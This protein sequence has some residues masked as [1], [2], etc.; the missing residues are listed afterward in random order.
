MERAIHRGWWHYVV[1][2]AVTA[3]AAGFRLYF[4]AAL[5]GGSPFI[6]FYP[7][8]VAGALYGGFLAGVLVIGLSIFFASLLWLEPV[9]RSFNIANASDVPGIILFFINGIVISLVCAAVLHTTEKVQERTQRLMDTN[10]RLEEEVEKRSKT[11]QELRSLTMELEARVAE[12]TEELQ[13]KNTELEIALE[14]VVRQNR[15]LDQFAYVVSHDLKAPLRAISNLSQWIKEDLPQE[16]QGEITENLDILQ[17][18]VY[19][20]ENL[21]NGILEYSR[22]GRVEAE[23]SEVNVSQLLQEIVEELS[24]PPGVEIIIAHP[25]PVLYTSKVRLRQ[26]FSNLLDNAI[27]HH[28]SSQGRVS[29]QVEDCGTYCRFSVDDDGPGIAPEFHE[30]IFGIFQTLQPKDKVES[31][32]VGLALV[33]KIV[34]EYGGTIS[35]RSHQGQ[36]A[37][38]RFTWPQ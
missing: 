15:E 38:F 32:G 2:A 11:E 27:K 8:I 20:M 10:T 1:A 35:L 6:T 18:R 7:A 37:S 14:R 33:K 3:A 30:R 24:P 12:R 28:H 31:T 9:G 16:C 23:K 36:G 29:V 4:L 13:N 19:R 5:G 21:I 34:E 17:N 25:M 22:I 26:V